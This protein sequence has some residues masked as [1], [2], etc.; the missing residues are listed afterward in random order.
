MKELQLC[1]NSFWQEF[2]WCPCNSIVHLYRR[3][4]TTWIHVL[5]CPSVHTTTFHRTRK[6]L[7]SSRNL[8]Y[9]SIFKILNGVLEANLSICTG[10]RRDTRKG[11]G[12]QVRLGLIELSDTGTPISLLL[13]FGHQAFKNL[14]VDCSTTKSLT[15][16]LSRL[17]TCRVK[18]WDVKHSLTDRWL[19]W[20]AIY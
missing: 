12:F 14:C 1:C 18:T 4:L 11:F 8:V 17:V 6:V 5:S 9:I 13:C 7:F 10:S 20:C 15:A 19:L 3:M 2:L 16:T